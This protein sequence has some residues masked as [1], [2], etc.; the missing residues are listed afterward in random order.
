M[1]RNTNLRCVF[2]VI[3]G[4][5]PTRNDMIK[6]RE[7]LNYYLLC[8]KIALKVPDNVKRPRL[9]RDTIW[10]YEICLRKAEFYSNSKSLLSKILALY[11]KY[12]LKKKSE[13]LSV[14]I[15]INV[16]GPGLSI[17]HPACIVVNS[18]AA[19]GKNCR[20]H[21]GV[22]IGATNGTSDAPIIGDNC[23]L[24]SGCKIIGKVTVA[25]NIAVGAG[26]V[27]VRDVLENNVSVGGVPAKII[28]NKGSGKNVIR[29]TNIIDDR[30]II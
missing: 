1:T 3:I 22:T 29:A 8:D 26:A 24:G 28:S 5:R 15:P 27:I 18:N 10:R 7:D 20:I 4:Y 13:K 16:F 2:R 11:Y 19:V 30:V 12:Q 6:S 17:A 25:N 14:Y 9:F 23:F 21:E